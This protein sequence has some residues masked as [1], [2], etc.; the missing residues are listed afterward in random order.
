MKPENNF[1]RAFIDLAKM[2]RTDWR[3]VALTYLLVKLLTLL[4]SLG[5]VIAVASPI[6]SER[7]LFHIPDA[8]KVIVYGVVEAAAGIFGLWL[9][10][11]KILKRSFRSLISTEMTFDI[12]RCLL[13]AVLY[14]AA[15]AVSFMAI[16]FFY[17]M[18]ADAWVI[19]P[20]HFEW[21][22]HNDQIVVAM[23]HLF[24]IPILAFA[25][26]LFFR[27]WLTQSIGRYIRSTITVV[28]LVAV[29]F[30]AAHSQYDLRL[31]ML[32]FVDSL[33][34]SALSLR[35]QRLELAI[36]AH[37]M[38][39]VC[40]TLYRLFFMGH[41]P[42]A[43]IPETTLDWCTLVILKGVLPF[44]LMYWVLQ[45][46]RGWFTPTGARLASLGDVQPGHL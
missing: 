33:G 24:V 39:N 8:E 4:F 2:G 16:S 6:F 42:H 21:P 28:A 7:R 10:C 18:R 22:H 27:A 43:K 34:F 11:K 12:R 9:A 38:M 13:G 1:S 23:V 17:S 36:G 29:L 37:S 46:T 26:E 19:T 5:S 41:L 3:S 31:K 20:L 25:E 32:I 30:A 35:D 45:K 15:N 14:L 44:A 40:A